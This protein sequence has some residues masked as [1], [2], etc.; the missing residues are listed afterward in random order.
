MRYVLAITSAA[1]I[2]LGLGGAEAKAHNNRHHVDMVNA[3]YHQ[4]LGRGAEPGG[5]HTWVSA[6]HCGAEPI[7]VQASILASDEY[8]CRH[9]HSE[10]GFVTGLYTDILCRTPCAQEVHDWL[11]RLRAIGCRKRLALE[12]FAAAGPELAR[13]NS[14]YEPITH[15]HH[16]PYPR[17]PVRTAPVVAPVAVRPVLPAPPLHT[18]GRGLRLGVSYTSR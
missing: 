4:Y 17:V 3:W 12:F 1:V 2:A 8:L 14:R 10:A 18:P 7:D 5:L 6:L 15:G 13:R 9:G 11:C 16:D